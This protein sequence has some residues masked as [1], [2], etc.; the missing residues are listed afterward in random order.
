MKLGDIVAWKFRVEMGIPS[1]VGV[2]VSRLTLEYD[3][4]PYWRVLF[5]ERGVL[6]CR[7]SDLVEV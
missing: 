2:I 5:G 3:P 4:W 1:E 7:E 6:Q